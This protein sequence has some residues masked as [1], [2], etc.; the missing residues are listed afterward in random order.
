MSVRQQDGG[1]ALN[2]LYSG[3]HGSACSDVFLAMAVVVVL[4]LVVASRMRPTV[5]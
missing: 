1:D 4:T 3:H 5:G 2:P